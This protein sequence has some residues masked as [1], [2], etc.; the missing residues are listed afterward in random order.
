MP[1]FLDNFRQGGKYDAQIVSHHA[2]LRR[3]EKSAE[4]KYLSISYLQTDYISL[5]SSSGCGRN[6]ERANSVQKKCTFC[7]GTNHSAE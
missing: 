5:D 2:K 6:S 1:T 4:Q 7:E 3:E